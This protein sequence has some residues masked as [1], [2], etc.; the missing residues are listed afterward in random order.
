MDPLESLSARIRTLEDREAIRNLK[1]RYA[2]LCDAKYHRGTLRIESELDRVGR[3]IAMLFTEDAIWDGGSRFGNSIGRGQIQERFSK[4]TFNYAIHFFTLPELVVNDD[5]ASGRWY[6]LEAAT[7]PDSTAVWIA[8]TE[9][10]EYRRAGE[11]WLIS[12]MK[13]NLDFIAP[14]ETGWAR[15]N[16]IG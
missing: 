2:Q 16:L 1:A 14:V 9:D 6:L 3:D 7:L 10:D 13:V 12:R 11:G 5:T 8:G 15:A 4:A